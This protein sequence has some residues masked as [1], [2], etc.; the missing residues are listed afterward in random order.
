M[1]LVFAVPGFALAGDGPTVAP[2]TVI[3]EARAET[4]V[5]ATG[6]AS[7]AVSADEIAVV[8]PSGS[9]TDVLLQ[10][11]AVSLDQNQQIHIRD[12]E[13]PQFQYQVNG[14]LVPLDIN[15]NP[16]FLSMIGTDFIKSLSLRVGV[17][18]AR[19]SYATGGVVDIETKDGC[20]APGGEAS[21]LFGMRETLQGSGQYGGCAGRLSWFVSGSYGASDTAFSQATPGPNPIHDHG[22]H[23]QAFGVFSYKLSDTTKLSL[24][25]S[26]S[27]SDDELPNQAGLAPQFV[28][29]GA[30]PPASADIDSRL[31]FRD[32]LAIL[33]LNSEP[34]TRFSWQIAYAFHA[35]RQDFEPDTVGELAYQGVASHAVH[36]DSDHTLEGDANW[37]L[38]AHTLSAGFY[39]GLYHVDAVDRSLVFPVD[40]ATGAVGTTL[41]EVDSLV[42]GDNIVSGLYVNDL[43]QVS[44]AVSLNLGLRWDAVTGATRGRQLDPTVNLSWRPDAATTL[45]AGVARDFQVPSWQGLSPTAQAA[46]ENTTAAGPPGTAQ[47][48]T[49]DDLVFDAGLSRR[50]GPHLT[51][52]LDAYYERTRRYLDTG[53]FGDVPIFAPFNYANGR[54]WGTELALDYKTPSLS[55]WANL[56]IGRNTQRGVVTGQFNFDPDELAYIDAHPIVL[57]HQP[58]V[59]ASAGAAWT[60]R[61]WTLSADALYSSGLRAGFADLVRLPPVFQVNLGIARRFRLPSGRSLTNRITVLNLSDRTNLIRPADGIGIFQAAYGP[62][63][64]VLDEISLT[65]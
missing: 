53:Q 49:E 39:A 59:G 52:S 64:T 63:L 2:V 3:G 29:A 17:L 44:R 42:D 61:D 46:F 20:Q 28:V 56:A 27:A 1:S 60:W 50:L 12:T 16:P 26:G 35:I 62:R 14:V 13:G 21:L 37:K 30:T 51:A 6:E 25:L 58:L 41:I 36:E 22:D 48:M 43:W 32:A 57:D 38:G 33:A 65:F 34:S 19:Y 24:I 40:P 5:A 11:P 47:P 10:M 4:P 45:H 15:T 55:V 31:N 8:A 9:L 7:Y 23:G 18:P 54:L